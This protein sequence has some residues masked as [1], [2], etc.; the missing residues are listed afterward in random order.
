MT[1]F[2]RRAYENSGLGTDH[3]RASCLF[4]MGGGVAG[5]KVVSEWPGLAA[6]QRDSNGDLR[7]TTDYR[8]ILAELLT[9]RL[10]NPQLDQVFLDYTPRF[11]D[12][13]TKSSA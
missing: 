4:V 3:G 8:D 12:L 7:V 1:E 10:A 5:G 2:G 11:H 6:S 13:I 9:R